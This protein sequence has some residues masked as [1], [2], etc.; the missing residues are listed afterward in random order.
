MGLLHFL[1]AG[2]LCYGSGASR[3]VARCVG[4]RIWCRH[5]PGT[6][7]SF[8]WQTHQGLRIYARV[9]H[10]MGRAMQWAWRPFQVRRAV[11]LLVGPALV[12]LGGH[13]VYCQLDFNENNHLFLEPKRKPDVEPQFSWP[14]FWKLL[15][16][17][18]QVLLTAVLLAFGAAILN[19]QIPLMLGEL[20]NVVS[21]Y[22]R[23]YAGN[24]LRDVREPALRLLSLYALQGFLTSGY[25]VL[26][27][28]VGERV[29]ATM[30]K[31][32]FRSL[33]RQDLAFFDAN[34]TGMLVNRLTSDIQ[35]FKSSFKQVISQGLRS[36]TQIA[37]C[38]ISLYLISPRLTGLL[39]VVL[40][41]LVGAGALIGS[42]LR[43]LSRRAQEQVAKATGVADEALGNVRTVRAFAME[44]REEELYSAE[45]DKSCQ[46]S[47]IL[48]MGIAVFQGL[49]NLV[50]N[51][52]VLG[53]I[54]AGGAMMA[55]NKLSAGDLMSFLVASQTVQRSM[56]NLSVLF[57]QVVRGL[58]AGARVFEFTMLE[59]RILLYG[60][61]IIPFDSLVGQVSFQNITFSYPTRPGHEVLKNFSLTLPPYKTVAIVGQSGGGKSTVAALLERFYDPN[62]GAVTLDG[63][64]I[65][66]I[67]PSWLRGQAIG[68]ISQE[69]VLF[70]TTIMENIRF[71][72]PDASDEEVYAAA[73][74]AN[75]D[76]FIRT[77]PEGYNTV[78]GERGVTL[79]GGQ[80]QRVAIARALIKNP[81]I[82]ILDEATSALD[83][84]SERVV[85]AALDRATTG[86]TVLVIAHRLSTI[87]GADFIVVL[88]QGKVAEVQRR[89]V[90]QDKCR[91]LRDEGRLS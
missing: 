54:F 55:G 34:K 62:Q 12:T 71:G 41:T 76:C 15:R 80:K 23:E 21:R 49:S 90:K 89:V 60:G 27:S 75:A 53:T 1:Q 19:I 67:D 22:T 14:E 10:G 11:G 8:T 45:V 69:P 50:L 9:Q 43:T 61:K 25:I 84:E 35:E 66:M 65:R 16:P 73:E 2:L 32:L 40:P 64:D 58:S 86:R 29:A 42:F 87:M 74:Q 26:L 57:G 7:G 85:Q 28:R 70:G 82:L 68:F 4:M 20:V 44:S 72:K 39:V 48:G 63:I 51:C 59:P 5:S 47:E 33:L 81:R 6:S 78:V 3:S 83:A 30:R 52:V 56:A 46:V 37:G 91:K 31:A 17:Q 24:Y 36:L 38:F 88:S 13:I 18:L 79:S 77:F